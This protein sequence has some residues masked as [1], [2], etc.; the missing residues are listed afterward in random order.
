[1]CEKVE[2]EI[3]IQEVEKEL[4]NFEN[5]IFKSYEDEFSF[6][7]QLQKSCIG[8]L[9]AK[10]FQIKVMISWYTSSISRSFRFR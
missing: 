2:E 1:M 7:R 6:W 5:V 10:I 8:T 4:R 3:R 9:T